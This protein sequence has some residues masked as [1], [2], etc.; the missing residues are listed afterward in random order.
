MTEPLPD[1]VDDVVWA[2][3]CRRAAAICRFLESNTSENTVTAIADLASD[4]QVSQATTYR[5][6]RRFR[7]D[8]TVISLIET[9][10]GRPTGHR[11]LDAQREE[12]IEKATRQSSL[13]SRSSRHSLD[14]CVEQKSFLR[15][16]ETLR[17]YQFNCHCRSHS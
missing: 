7:A 11:A 14:K 15:S 4:L 6:L 13:A 16:E 1:E 12:I 17:H 8:R 10:R 5:L 2:E 3:A 9:K